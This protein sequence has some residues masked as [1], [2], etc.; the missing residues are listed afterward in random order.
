[1]SMNGSRVKSSVIY[2]R[3][4]VLSQI[5]HLTHL[6]TISWLGTG[7]CR[8]RHILEKDGLYGRLVEFYCLLIVTFLSLYKMNI[9]IIDRGVMNCVNGCISFLFRRCISLDASLYLTICKLMQIYID[10]FLD[11]RGFWGKSSQ[12]LEVDL[13]L[14]LLGATLICSNYEALRR[15]R[16]SLILLK[17]TFCMYHAHYAYHGTQLGLVWICSEC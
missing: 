17:S 12:A 6:N 13:C 8:Y 16:F 2:H 1:M 10:R 11:S 3:C 4:G 15:W 9:Y 7:C 14:S 5:C